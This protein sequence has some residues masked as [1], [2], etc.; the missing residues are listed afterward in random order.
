[1]QGVVQVIINMNAQTSGLGHSA[2]V[3]DEV[4]DQAVVL[5][6][7][8]CTGCGPKPQTVEDAVKCGV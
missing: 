8:E 3:Q 5:S 6:W 2:A 1:M 4:L 7:G